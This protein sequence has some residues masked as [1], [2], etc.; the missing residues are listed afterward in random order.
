MGAQFSLINRIVSEMGIF[1]IPLT[2]SIPEHAIAYYFDMTSQ[3]II[4]IAVVIAVIFV[5]YRF[6]AKRG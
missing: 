1:D 5:A 6:F 3:G 4:E 2:T